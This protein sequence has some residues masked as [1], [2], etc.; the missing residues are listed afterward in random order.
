MKKLTLELPALYG[1][2]HVIEVRRILFQLPGVDHVYAS[3]S[4]QVVEVTY[5]PARLDEGEITSRLGEAGYLGEWSLAAEP[6]Q[7]IDALDDIGRYLRH[8]TAYEQARQVGFAQEVG[9]VTRAS[10]PCPG[11]GVIFALDEEN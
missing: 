2:H 6:D 9:Q 7:A 4:F 5:D 10:W 8:T 3:S 1:D 11:L